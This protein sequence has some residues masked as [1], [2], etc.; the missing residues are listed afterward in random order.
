[1]AT[2]INKYTFDTTNITVPVNSELSS[3]APSLASVSGTTL[4]LASTTSSSSGTFSL[5][6]PLIQL[7]ADIDGSNNDDY[8]GNA[9]S[10][11]A[12]GTIMAVG[13]WQYGN[14]NTGQV[15]FYK[16]SSGSWSALG[17][18]ITGSEQHSYFG[19]SVSLNADGTRVA[20]GAYGADDGAGA[21]SGRVQVYEYS[22]S[23]WSQ[24]G[25][26]ISGE[27][28]E[29]YS[30]WSV[31]LNDAGSIVAIGSHRHKT[32]GH[33]GTENGRIQV[34]EYSSSTWSQLG[35]DID[36]VNAGEHF[37]YDVSLN[38]DGTILA[39]GAGQTTGY[40]RIYQYISG[41]W[42][43]LGDTIVGDSFS[44]G[45]S[46]M[47]GR[48]I[49]LN[50]DG[51]IV[52]IGAS[53]NN[54][55]GT[56]SGT[57]RI[58][59]YSTSTWSQLGSDIDG[60]TAWDYSGYDVALN[61]DGDIIAIGAHYN[62]GNGSN[63]G[64]VR[65]YKYTNSSWSQICTDTDGE[66][67]SDESGFSVAL[68]ADGMTLAIGAPYNDGGGSNSGQVKVYEVPTVTNTTYNYNVTMATEINKY[69]FDTTNITVPV[70]SELSS[71]APSLASVSGTTLTLASTT[72]SSS[73]TFS[74]AHPLIQVGSDIQDGGT[75]ARS[76]HSVSLSDDGTIMAVGAYGESRDGD[77]NVGAVRVYKYISGSWSQIGSTLRAETQESS[78]TFPDDWFGYSVKLNSAGNILAVGARRDNGPYGNQKRG[79]VKVYIYSGSSWSR[80]GSDIDAWRDDYGAKWGMSVALNDAGTILAAGAPDGSTD[81]DTNNRGLVRV[82]RYIGSDWTRIA[83]SEVGEANSDY[84]GW[85]V[86]LNSS[87]S[88]LAVGAIKNDDGGTDSG[89]VRVY[90]INTTATTFT[91]SLS[92]IGG[93]IDGEDDGDY[94]GYTVDLNG[95]GTILAIGANRAEAG[96]S[97]RGHVKVYEY[98][99]SSWSQI[100]DNINGSSSGD[101]SGITVS[102]SSDGTILAI[103]S[104]GNYVKLY[105]YSS[106]SWS[107][108]SITLTGV[109][110]F[111]YS[112]S[113][114]SDGSYLA[115]GAQNAESLDGSAAVYQIPTI[116]N[117][118]YVYN[119]NSPINNLYIEEIHIITDNGSRFSG[120]NLLHYASDNTS[121]SGT[122]DSILH[123]LNTDKGLKWVVKVT[124]GSNAAINPSVSGEHIQLTLEENVKTEGK[125][126]FLQMTYSQDV[127][128]G[129]NESIYFGWS[130]QGY[131]ILSPT[132]N[133]G[134]SGDYLISGT[135]STQNVYLADQAIDGDQ[136]VATRF[137]L[138]YAGNGGSYYIE[139]VGPYHDD[140][141][142][143][144][145]KNHSG[146]TN[147]P[148]IPFLIAGTS[149]TT[150]LSGTGSVS[151]GSYIRNMAGLSQ[152]I[153]NNNDK[154]GDWSISSQATSTAAATAVTSNTTFTNSLT[155]DVGLT[156]EQ[157]GNI[158]SQLNVSTSNTN[159]LQ[160]NGSINIPDKNL[161][162][163]TEIQ[164][165][166]LKSAIKS[167]Y[168]TELGVSQ[169]RII[170]TLSSGSIIA[171]VEVYGT[172]EE[173]S[174]A[175][176]YNNL[177]IDEVRI[178]TDSGS[179]FSANN[180]L[181]NI[182]S[183]TLPTSTVINTG[184]KWVVQITNASNATIAT[185]NTIKLTI[186]T[187]TTNGDK[188]EQSFTH[189]LGSSI[190]DNGS[191]YFGWSGQGATIVSSNI[192]YASTTNISDPTT[193]EIYLADQAVSGSQIVGTRFR[194]FYNGTEVDRIGSDYVSSTW[195]TNEN[196]TNIPSIP[197]LIQGAS[198]ATGLSG[199]GAVSTGSYTRKIQTSITQDIPT[200]TDNTG[201]WNVQE[202][203]RFSASASGDPH[204]T[205]LEGGSYKFK[206]TGPFRYFEDIIE[207]TPLIINGF[208]HD[209]KH[210]DGSLVDWMYSDICGTEEHP[211]Y[212]K[213]ICIQYGEKMILIDTGFRG[214]NATVLEC[215]GMDYTEKGLTFHKRAKRMHR[216]RETNKIYFAQHN[217]EP[218]SRELP[219]LTRNQ[220]I[221]PIYS[222]KQEL[223]MSIIIQNVNMYNYQP[224]R[225]CV[226]LEDRYKIS[227]EAKG[228]IVHEKYANYCM[229]DD[230]KS[231]EL[232]KDPDGETMPEMEVAAEIR[233]RLYN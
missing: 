214:I 186:E 86:A 18:S 121:D 101:Q 29:D 2:E 179:R 61:N 233:N 173:A 46:D 201:D 143:I 168:A 82:Y 207:D 131:T 146:E 162:E 51:T 219:A 57:T 222:K 164:Q 37:G 129:V 216:N 199:T 149:S 42:T 127:S 90:S 123:G 220:I 28:Y 120:N 20:I 135:G 189:T 63:S 100:G 188:Y 204:I 97:T 71:D 7:G 167:S 1:M 165:N 44:G 22:S 117:T 40:V 3:D 96:G 224:S 229:V 35:S 119:V 230:M 53:G 206:H 34:Y 115:V 105:K 58:Y 228:C 195:R 62:N 25:S 12:D 45:S 192:A 133:W 198:T 30:G 102:I 55:A 23:T 68:N 166:N 75:D 47:A 108:I 78:D 124:N 99:S 6:H 95:D 159:G 65:I 177:Y 15:S 91:Q 33:T 138:R 49:S 110:A 181:N 52:A 178:I 170:V 26:D 132:G 154:V 103:G 80:R 81:N 73:G 85:S 194:L 225:T 210:A 160:Y 70:N 139:K 128:I 136:V 39:G 217:N 43:Q 10:L 112:I 148:A 83:Y 137:V 176:V 180:I 109:G 8:F 54:G 56:D 17:S 94:F 98:S 41:S 163:I 88:I 66:A 153:P 147:V 196:Q 140:P 218:V 32:G 172:A 145:W 130:D 87:G 122:S 212:I 74:L 84:F 202:D 79:S 142:D 134:G 9:V 107:Q 232:L 60:E 226:L 211:E 200:L 191:I 14:H 184:L 141:G 183:G 111:G 185:A 144:V 126:F 106:G 193:Q 4:T 76:G 5:A 152:N 231:S 93:D 197:F 161:S 116:T 151:T 48:S 27:Y 11:S 190:A 156:T 114:T 69:T 13:A 215:S 187:I 64:H 104:F 223:L 16:Y 203:D 77:A 171:N 21:R 227:N 182:S 209:G 67:S 113:L 89:S 38:Y 155:T 24:L 50:Y 169:D 36:G 59:K 221:V 158:T 150:G 174:S 208:S 19:Y 92:R 205:T 72:S 175:P 125:H 31:S 213:K 157:I 118:T